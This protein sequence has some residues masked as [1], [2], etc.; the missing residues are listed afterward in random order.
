VRAH[1]EAK[2]AAK[3]S[4]KRAR[5]EK[6]KEKKKRVEEERAKKKRA[7]ELLK[8]PELPTDK[9]WFNSAI[10]AKIEVLMKEPQSMGMS[11]ASIAAEATRQVMADYRALDAKRT[12]MKELAKEFKKDPTKLQAWLNAHQQDLQTTEI[13]IEEVINDSRH[14]N[15]VTTPPACSPVVSVPTSPTMDSLD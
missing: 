15:E 12:A 8:V 11:A 14:L 5:E 10:R 4:K 2:D 9:E 6:E 1:P 3:E 13:E 7:K